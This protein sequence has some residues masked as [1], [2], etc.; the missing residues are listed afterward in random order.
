MFAYWNADYPIPSH[1]WVSEY[2]TSCSTALS[3]TYIPLDPH[4][5]W[6]NPNV[7][8][9]FT[10]PNSKPMFLPDSD[11]LMIFTA[12]ENNKTTCFVFFSQGFSPHLLLDSFQTW[13]SKPRSY[14]T[15]CLRRY[16]DQWDIYWYN[17]VFCSL[18]FHIVAVSTNPSASCTEIVMD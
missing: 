6:L 13:Y 5:W 14:T 3:R 15:H 2:T 16:F 11:L 12:G 9:G 1:G 10:S 17:I 4:C 7:L 18:Y 8:V